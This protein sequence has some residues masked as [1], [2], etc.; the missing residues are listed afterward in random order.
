MEKIEA[1]VK[2]PWVSPV[3]VSIFDREE[4]IKK[5]KDLKTQHLTLFIDSLVKNNIAGIGIK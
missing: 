2:S 3:Q 1:F 4:A 5:A